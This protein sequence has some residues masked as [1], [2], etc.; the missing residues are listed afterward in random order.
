MSANITRAPI[1]GETISE[2]DFLTRFRAAVEAAGGVRAFSRKTGIN[3]ATVCMAVN[4]TKPITDRIAD[5]MGF[6][7]LMT[8]RRTK[9]PRMSHA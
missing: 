3:Q 8:F 9:E 6:L 2:L 4:G 7:R 1:I 5:E